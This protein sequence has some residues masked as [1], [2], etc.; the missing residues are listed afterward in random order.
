MAAVVKLGPTPEHRLSF[1]AR[2]FAEWR[3]SGRGT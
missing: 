2:C 3:S 1:N